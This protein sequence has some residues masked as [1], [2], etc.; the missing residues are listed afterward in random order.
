MT[1]SAAKKKRTASTKKSKTP[2]T[3]AKTSAAKSGAAKPSAKKRSAAAVK[4][5]V[6]ETLFSTEEVWLTRPRQS[7]KSPVKEQEEDKNTIPMPEQGPTLTVFSKR[8]GHLFDPL[9]KVGN[10]TPDEEEAYRQVLRTISDRTNVRLRQSLTFMAINFFSVNKIP[11]KNILT[12]KGEDFTLE[13]APSVFG[14]P[15]LYDADILTFATS[16]LAEKFKN[17]LEHDKDPEKLPYMSDVVFRLSD[18]NRRLGRRSARNMEQVT[19]ALK[20]LLMSHMTIKLTNQVGDKKLTLGKNVGQFITDYKFVQL[21]EPGKEPVA[22][23]QVRLADW[24]VRDVAGNYTLWFPDSYFKM[25]AFEKGLFMVA[26]GRIGLREFSEEEDG[27]RVLLSAS[28]E[29]L[30]REPGIHK[31]F[32]IAKGSSIDYF[33]NSVTLSDL[34]HILRWK[35]PLYKLRN[36]IKEVIM[37]G[38]FPLYVLALDECCKQAGQQ[39]LFFFRNDSR[40]RTNILAADIGYPGFAE[41]RRAL[42]TREK[43]RAAAGLPDEEEQTPAQPSMFEDIEALTET[44]DAPFEPDLH[45]EPEDFIKMPGSEGITPT[46]RDALARALQDEQRSFRSE[47]G[48]TP[49][50]ASEKAARIIR[51]VNVTIERPG[52]PVVEVVDA[53]S[54]DAGPTADKDH[55]LFNNDVVEAVQELDAAPAAAPGGDAAAGADGFSPEADE[56]SKAAQPG[57]SPNAPAPDSDPVLDVEDYRT[58]IEREIEELHK[59]LPA[60]TQDG[61]LVKT[62]SGVCDAAAE[63]AQPISDLIVP[64]PI[65]VHQS[66]PPTPAPIRRR[67]RAIGVAPEPPVPLHAKK[68]RRT[69]KK[70]DGE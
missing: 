7:K 37:D 38:S 39:R 46:M 19:A 65:Q 26:R 54:S 64:L 52:E 67:R 11:D 58:R 1:E 40:L 17:H 69:P 56:T 35:A 8:Q 30:M 18:F 21:E 3:S 6:A 47:A 2:R 60:E 13:F 32:E 49:A 48:I 66:N 53:P 23:I 24:I 42:T 25:R 28:T 12:I 41:M 29:E 16:I 45:G 36:R 14:A 61:S 57:G 34:A 62:S 27:K 9:P 20:R 44:E 5:P 4:P 15:T 50:P 33:F 59:V 22:A 63:S 68:R 70:K 10:M 43:L 51:N 31:S 55:D